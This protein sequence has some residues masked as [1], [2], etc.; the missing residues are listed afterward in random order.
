MINFLQAAIPLP[1]DPP[2]VGYGQIVVILIL[3]II[4]VPFLLL[5][6]AII[7]WINRH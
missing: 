4:V 2:S 6:R 5:V 1:P 7:R 3:L